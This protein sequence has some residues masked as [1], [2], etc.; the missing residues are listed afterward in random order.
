MMTMA[1]A[2]S[3]RPPQHA[4]KRHQEEL[5]AVLATHMQDP[6]PPIIRTMAADV[7]PNNLHSPLVRLDKILDVGSPL[8]EV[9][10]GR[11][12]TMEINVCHGRHPIP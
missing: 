5:F 11:I 4:R 7:V 8:V 2:T 6:G 1:T 12:G 10:P 9:E 3:M